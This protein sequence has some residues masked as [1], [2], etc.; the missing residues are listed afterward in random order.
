MG[1]EKKQILQMV[2]DGVITAE[3]GVKLLEALE[4]GDSKRRSDNPPHRIH[5][6]IIAEGIG[7]RLAEIGPL[8]RNAVCEAF[9]GVGEGNLDEMV[10]IDTGPTADFNE[11]AEPMEIETGT[12]IEIRNMGGMRSSGGE[13]VLR[14][15]DGSSLEVQEGVAEVASADDVCFVQWKKGTL[16]LGIPSTASVLHV[17]LRG[18][19][20]SA[21]NIS[22]ELDLRTKGGSISLE[23]QGGGFCVRTMGGCIVIE[24]SDS[25]KTDSKASTMGGSISLVVPDSVS[26]EVSA[27][28]IGGDVVV[29]ENLGE[30]STSRSHAGSKVK[31]LIGSADEPPGIKLK[32]M[33]GSIEITEKD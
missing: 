28:A 5:H 8:V 10:D 26:A 2:A 20:V 14:G 3:D 11:F 25:W 22:S 16:A 12:T 18:S 27:S 7:E 32:T 17:N 23:G 30:V 29:S 24:L 1:D 13:L 31:V 19:S 6:R 4:K 9:I 33:G 21:E 15:I